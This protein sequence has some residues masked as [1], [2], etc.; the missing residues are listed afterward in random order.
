MPSNH[1]K[2]Y[3]F[4]LFVGWIAMNSS[5]IAKALGLMVLAFGPL[6]ADVALAQSCPESIDITERR[7]EPSPGWDAAEAR[8]NR[9]LRGVIIVEGELHQDRSDN[10]SLKPAIDREGQASWK[11]VG[12][13]GDAELWMQCIYEGSK[14]LLSKRIEPQVRQCSAKWTKSTTDG[15][16]TMQ[17]ACQ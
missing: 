10:A 8:S 14:I 12:P 3:R 5:R 1:A 11:F 6:F 7:Q 9:P 15:R 16:K 13:I 17:A 4:I 2:D